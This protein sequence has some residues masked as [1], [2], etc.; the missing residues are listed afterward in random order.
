[1]WD[2]LPA[3]SPPAGGAK[4]VGW[5]LVGKEPELVREVEKFRLDIVCLTSTPSKGSGTSLLERGWIL[6]HSGVATGERRRAGVA[7]LI[8]PR[9]GACM[10]EF[11]PVDEREA[12]LRCCL[13]L[14]S[15]QQFRVSTLFGLLGGGAGKC[16]LWGFPHSAGG[17]QRSRWQRQ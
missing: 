5:G 4:G 2:P 9:L 17:L 1:M 8:A 13:C 16:S 6:F 11:T 15:K 10:L 12:S 14:C 7:I 3:G